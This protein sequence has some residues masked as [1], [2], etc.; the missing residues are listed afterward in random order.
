MRC[1]GQP[2]EAEA[3]GL[4]LRPDERL[5]LGIGLGLPSAAVEYPIMADFELKV[6][7]LFCRSDPTT[8]LVRGDGLPGRAN[9]VPFALD[10]HQRGAFDGRRLDRDFPAPES[11]LA[12][13][14]GRETHA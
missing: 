10:R 14:R 6:M 11:G 5:D 13:D 3:A 9:I 1:R 12:A 2:H 8:E 7:G 4:A